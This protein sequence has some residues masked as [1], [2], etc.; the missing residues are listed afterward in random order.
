MSW[1]SETVEAI[2]KLVLIE[3]RIERLTKQTDSLGAKYQELDGR[4]L[5]IETKFEMFEKI[6]SGSLH[7]ISKRKK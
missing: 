4:L 1:A 3:D 2:R 6:A 7:A 5:R